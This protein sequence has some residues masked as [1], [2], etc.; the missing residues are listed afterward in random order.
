MT[1]ADSKKFLKAT[2]F[3]IIAFFLMALYGVIGKYAALS[4]NL[5]W[6][7]FL[8]YVLSF[9]L[10]LP[11]IAYRGFHSVKTQ[12]YPIHF[13]R[14]FIGLSASL[15]YLYAITKVPL[16]NATLLYSSSPF[17]IPL[18][19]LALFKTEISWKSWVAIFVGFVGIA[20]IIQP[21]WSLL[22]KLGNLYG[23]AAGILL[24]FV[25]VLVRVLVKTENILTI[26]FYFSGNAA[27]IQLPLVIYFFEEIP[28]LSSFPLI[29]VLSTIFICTQ[30][31][32]AVAYQNA[33]PAKIGVFQYLTILF[34][35][36]FDWIIWGQIPH[37]IE[38]LGALIVIIA[39]IITIRE[40][41]GLKK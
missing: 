19:S 33:P 14:A 38:L 5:L 27:L 11:F 39:G 31:C 24:A 21:D 9:I 36:I 3:V 8:T 20:L 16:A 15:L 40:G 35:G 2:I 28:P 10:L 34:V 1:D 22:S 29:F 17:F 4:V 32:L 30:Y 18:I 7:N 23:L 37:Q 12:V 13:L 25:F 26:L 6:V 41:Y